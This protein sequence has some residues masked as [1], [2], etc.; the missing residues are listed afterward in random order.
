M[1]HYRK[2]RQKYRK[3]NSADKKTE[4]CTFCSELEIGTNTISENETM[5]VIPNRV[6]Y[7][8]FEGRGVT[9]HYMVIPKRHVETI[10]DF[11]DQEK[12]DQMTII[13]KYEAIGFNVYARGVGSVT[14]SV[15][16]QHTHLIKADNKRT[17]LFMYAAKPHFVVKV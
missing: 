3:L 4:T 8:V 10:T 16:H 14:R 12:I 13:G 6:S 1:Y 17:R 15:K 2:T 9:E 7:D 11:S 5:F